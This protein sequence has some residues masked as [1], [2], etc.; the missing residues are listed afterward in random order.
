MA[1]ALLGAH[2]RGRAVRAWNHSS[3]VLFARPVAGL[4]GDGAG[5]W[6]LTVLPVVGIIGLSLVD[7][8][9][10]VVPGRTRR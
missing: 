7:T 8:S 10:M 6:Q 4:G 9:R 5:L 3:L 1:S 2:A